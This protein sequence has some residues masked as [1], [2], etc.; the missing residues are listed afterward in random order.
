MATGLGT[1]IYAVVVF[2]TTP[3]LTHMWSTVTVG[4]QAGAPAAGSIRIA[5][6]KPTAA[7]DVT[8]VDA[9]TPWVPLYWIAVGTP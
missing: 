1:V 5:S 9:T 4:D 7:A 8:P 6:R 2:T 3:T